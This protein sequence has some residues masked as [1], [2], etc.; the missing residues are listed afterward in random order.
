MQ[1]YTLTETQQFLQALDPTTERF[2]FQ[3]FDDNSSRKDSS[4]AV[5]LHGTLT[6]HLDQLMKLNQQGAGV[7]VCVNAT[8]FNGRKLENVTKV[9]AFFTDHDS[10]LPSNY[11][12]Q[13]TMVVQT[14]G[15]KGHAYWCLKGGTELDRFK[16]DQQWLIRHYGSDSAVCD[17]TRVMRLPGFYH[18][19][20]AS[21]PKLVQLLS[22]DAQLLYSPTE[23]LRGVETLTKANVHTVAL[24]YQ[25]SLQA[26][27]DAVEEAVEGRRNDTLNKAAFA[28][29]MLAVKGECTEAD[30]VDAIAKA[31][32]SVGLSLNEV[33]ATVPRAVQDGMKAATQEVKSSS[34]KLIQVLESEYQH[35]LRWNVLQQK[36][37]VDGEVVDF[38]T[39]EMEIV[40]HHDIHVETSKLTSYVTALAKANQF[41][42]VTEY[43]NRVSA[44]VQPA[45]DIIDRLATEALGLTDVLERKYLTRFLIAAVARAFEPGCKV[46]TVLILQG[47]QGYRK[48]TF[49]QTLFTPEYFM[50]LGDAG[51]ERD[52]LL[53]LHQ[54][55]CIEYG[56]FETAASKKDVSAMKNFLSRQ[57]DNFREPYG[58]RAENHLRRFVLCGTTNKDQFLF[59]ETGNRRFWVVNIPQPINLSWVEQYRDEVW[60][61]AVALYQAGQQWWLTEDEQVLSDST[62]KTYEATS[63]WHD[64]IVAWLQGNYCTTTGTT[65]Y[66]GQAF[67]TKDV[68]L[69]AVGKPAGQWTKGDEMQ[70]SKVLK[71]LGLE[72]N[73]IRVDGVKGKYWVGTPQLPQ[74]TNTFVLDDSLVLDDQSF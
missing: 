58:S 33:N 63:V 6:Q 72:N 13:P 59:D 66:K 15:A 57:V 31:G 45:S 9:R 50:T 41:N 55:W 52:E 18:M 67:Q 27:V 11:H 22:C 64:V 10:Y 21:N 38:S 25:D 73:Q 28:A 47:K 1:T 32:L 16:A 14:S 54:H 61:A 24:N 43:L 12:V 3:T 48:T 69:N 39:L 23:A 51:N 17:A 19:K 53:S 44:E 36:P 71:S 5:I 42:P 70:V 8:D 37:V 68:L 35:R 26:L 40:K 46:D 30:A 34:A 4:L 62:N 20:D 49:F 65:Y 74:T 29:G 60:S 7:F 2:T 56:E